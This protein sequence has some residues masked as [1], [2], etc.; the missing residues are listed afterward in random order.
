VG[1]EGGS[2]HPLRSQC[3]MRSLS[4]SRRD[5]PSRSSQRTLLLL[6]AIALL[7]VLGPLALSFVQLMRCPNVPSSSVGA[8][9]AEQLS[10]LALHNT[11]KL[12]NL[13]IRMAALANASLEH[14]E[15]STFYEQQPSIEEL[16]GRFSKLE[17][18]PEFAAAKHATVQRV[19][20]AQLS[21]PATWL[22]VAFVTV[23]R[24]SGAEYLLDTLHSF[25]HALSVDSGNPLLSAVQ[26]VVINNNEPAGGHE[27]CQRAQKKYGKLAVFIV[28]QAPPP[29]I[30]C[31]NRAGGKTTRKVYQQSCDLVAALQGLQTLPRAKY[32]M[33][34]EDDWLLCPNGLTSLV[35]FIDKAT[36]YDREWIALR[37]S[38][39]FNGVVLR[40]AD[41]P[42]LQR[43][44]AKHAARRP[45]D[46]LLFEW[47]SG[48]RDDTRKHA[49]NRSYRIFRHNLFYHIGQVST[50][51][52]PARRFTPGCYSLLYDWLL[53]KEVFNREECPEDDVWPCTESARQR[54]PFF[55]EA[56]RLQWSAL[57]WAD[58]ELKPVNDP[59]ARRSER[60]AAA[61]P[62][63]PIPLRAAARE[64][65][66]LVAARGESC[67]QA[68][69]KAGLSCDEAALPGLNGCRALRAHFQ[70]EACD[71][72]V[73]ADQPAFVALDA[74]I[75]SRPGSCLVNSKTPHCEG[76]HPLTSRLCQC[77]TAR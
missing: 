12:F 47:F 37:V 55:Q 32:T 56:P 61:L 34:M 35:Y 77:R 53:P 67:S 20:V 10:P 48:E 76:S 42:S 4:A 38:Y 23:S 8:S 28:K 7:G 31:A 15:E 73:G 3:L 33:L 57:E 24:A 22:R 44:L 59:A 60:Q 75:E 36:R 26:L 1:K 70:C 51:A 2:T 63:A 9:L 49:F 46:H 25:E 13:S 19:Q 74:P 68:C 71:N 69:S 40:D 54:P 21:S 27:V 41:L 18:Q 39:G 45:P 52:Q 58:R 11:E 6:L 17:P 16:I 50:L 5:A 65:E 62:T 72:S 43:H 14:A 29:E 66:G 30:A 64:G